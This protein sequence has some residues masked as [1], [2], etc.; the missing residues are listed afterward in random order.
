[1]LW[2]GDLDAAPD[3]IGPGPLNTD[4]RPR[5]EF[6]A[7]RLTR[8]GPDGDKDWFTGAA[9]AA[10][11]DRLAARSP[12]RSARAEEARRAGRA[13][14]RY[15]LA[16]RRGAAAAAARRE[17]EVRALVPEVVAAADEPSL[18]EARRTLATLRAEAARVRRAIA[19]LEERRGGQR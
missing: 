1:M 12:A 14:A 11:A 5:L 13:L 7:P 18:G 2:M 15:A 17:A 10:F 3:V 8:M 4:D 6:L 19:A 16:V 9:L